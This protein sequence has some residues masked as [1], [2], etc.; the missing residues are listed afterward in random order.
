MRN[1]L[2]RLVKHFSSKLEPFPPWLCPSLGHLRHSSLL[3]PANPVGTAVDESIISSIFSAHHQSWRNGETSKPLQTSVYET[4][5][6]AQT[7]IAD[8]RS[9]NISILMPRYWPHSDMETDVW[10]HFSGSAARAGHIISQFD[11]GDI[12]YDDHVK[13]P[14]NY[15]HKLKSGVVALKEFLRLERP[16]VVFFDGNFIPRGKSIDRDVIREL[17]KDFNFRLCTFI[18]DL[19]DLQSQ[20]RLEYWGEVSDLVVVLNSKTRHYVDFANKEKVLV[21]GLIP[22]DDV[23]F[24]RTT[25]RDIGLGFCGGKGRRRDVFHSFA[26]QCALPT[27]AHFVDDKKYLTDGEFRD[28]LGRSRITFSNGY[29]GTI[30]GISY[31]VMTGRI[32][33]A[34]LSGSLLVYESGSQIDDYLVPFVHYVP[35]DNVHELVHFCRYLLKHEEKRA[36]MAN[37][38]YLFLIEHYSSKKFWNCITQRLCNVVAP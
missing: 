10:I 30:A 35:V 1:L 5:K 37:E 21:V 17:K 2:V 12:S 25:Q 6:L 36:E 22:W 14:M 20:S 23:L 33:E 29:A 11:I 8:R 26:E 32:T 3:G 31:S 13:Q 7:K 24:S 16:D 28:F 34:I 4:N 18:G 38:A 19:H 27:T 9:L 15:G